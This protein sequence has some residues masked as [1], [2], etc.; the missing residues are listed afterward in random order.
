[1]LIRERLKKICEGKIKSSDGK[2]QDTKDLKKKAKILVDE[3]RWLKKMDI[4]PFSTKD[5]KTLNKIFDEM[6]IQRLGEQA[7]KK[8]FKK[9]SSIPSKKIPLEFGESGNYY[10]RKKEI[11]ERM[12][13]VKKEMDRM[14]ETNVRNAKRRLDN[15]SIVWIHSIDHGKNQKKVF[16][17][18][19]RIKNKIYGKITPMKYEDALKYVKERNPDFKMK[20]DE[21]KPRFRY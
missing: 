3:M 7:L 18:G 12:D 2:Y 8:G 10:V 15:A 1:M 20:E 19:S 11:K 5:L 21:T 16:S 17:L 6:Y 4:R 14:N 9:Q 13:N